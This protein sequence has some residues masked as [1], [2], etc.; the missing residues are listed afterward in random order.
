MAKRN[1]G[2]TKEAILKRWKEGYGQGESSQYKPWLT[3]QDV[4]SNGQVNR[5][6]GWKTG[7]VHHLMSLNELRYFYLLEWSPV[8][9]DIREQ[10]PLWPYEETQDLARELGMRYPTPPGGGLYVMTSDFRLTVEGGKDVVRT[11]KEAGD[12]DDE[13]TIIKLDIERE[14]WARRGVDWGIL[15]A[16]DLP[17]PV[18][19]NIQWLHPHLTLHGSSLDSED[20]PAI[21]RYLTSEVHGEQDSLATIARRCD[22]DLG[23]PPGS[24]LALARH[25][26]ASRQWQVDITARINP[27]RP[28][29]LQRAQGT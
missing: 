9:A 13:A 26:L 4:P 17:M 6:L 21:T 16:E 22:D 11:V 18:V 29:V 20:V 25:L 27:S 24:C 10:F 3:I 1:R 14:Y 23:L 12:L 2:M 15:V 19:E 7:R 8:V 5:P 28:I